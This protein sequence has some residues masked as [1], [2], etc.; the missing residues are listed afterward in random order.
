[1]TCFSTR[2]GL[3]DPSG[4]FRPSVH[5]AEGRAGV[6][7]LDPIGSGKYKRIE[8]LWWEKGGWAVVGKA[9]PQS[10]LNDIELAGPRWP[11]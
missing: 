2:R 6:T 1:V 11:K 5:C 9:T 7:F 3:S 10:S 4:F 8:K